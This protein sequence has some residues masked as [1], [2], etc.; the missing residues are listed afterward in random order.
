MIFYF[1]DGSVLYFNDLRQFGWVKLFEQK[2]RLAS[3][4]E[5][6]KLG[7]EPLTQDFKQ[8][9]FIRCLTARANSR[10]YQAL[11]DQKCV[12]GVG[13]IYA[14]E[15]L[16]YARIRPTRRC[17]NTKIQEY[18]KLYSG[19]KKILNQAIK[20]RGTTIGDYLDALGDFGS[21]S[22][23]LKVYGRAG[24]RCARKDCSG[25]VTRIKI[26]NRS[27]FYCPRCQR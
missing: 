16:F 25:Q 9:E 12:V 20:A 13:N 8:K 26:N 22:K 11:M 6:L 5:H 19:I 27:A 15:S 14:N 24:E 17:R 7:P 18:K 10:V 23:Q 4:L 1:N 2:E 3:Y 21:F